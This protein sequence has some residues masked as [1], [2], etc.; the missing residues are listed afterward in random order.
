M[1][2]LNLSVPDTNLQVR[3]ASWH[4]NTPDWLGDQ[5]QTPLVNSNL[6]ALVRQ[7]PGRRRRRPQFYEQREA[8]RLS[9]NRTQWPDQPQPG[10][11][12]RSSLVQARLEQRQPAARM[13]VPVLPPRAA[14]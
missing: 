1:L 10:L 2:G 13:A 9:F 6:N 5:G 14:Y 7:R 4:F 11:R 3:L 8:P 12:H